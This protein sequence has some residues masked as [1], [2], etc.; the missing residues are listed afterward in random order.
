MYVD[1]CSLMAES[2]GNLAQGRSES[3]GEGCKGVARIHGV[4][5]CCSGLA[6]SAS[7]DEFFEEVPV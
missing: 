3:L 1:F 2:S 4:V 6:L 5:K 7:G